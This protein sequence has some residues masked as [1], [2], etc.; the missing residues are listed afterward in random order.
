MIRIISSNNNIFEVRID[1]IVKT[2]KLIKDIVYDDGEI[3]DDDIYL[4]NIE[5]DELNIILNINKIY[6]ENNYM[7]DKLK[8]NNKYLNYINNLNID[9][10]FKLIASVHYLYIEYL[11]DLLCDEFIKLIDNKNKYELE[12]IFNVKLEI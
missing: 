10:L 12:K 7:I 11:E 1:E 9:S 3:I 8:T 2:S 6:S 4:N 5:Y